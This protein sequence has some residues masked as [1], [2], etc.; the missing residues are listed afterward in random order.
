[1][2]RISAYRASLVLGSAIS[3]LVAAPAFAESSAETAAAEAEAAAAANEIV[4]SGSPIRD[5]LANSL[6]LQRKAPNIISAITADDA[7]QFPDQT[8]AAA[9][10][11]LPGIG[12]QR[13]Q[14]QERYVQVRGAPTRW[15]VVSFDDVNIL[16][17][18]ERVFRFD[19]VPAALISTVELNKTLLPDMPAEA[20]A[21]RVNIKTYSAMANPGFHGYIDL[22]YGFVDLGN[23]PQEQAA[24]RLS[25]SN[26]TFGITVAGSHSMFEQQTDNSE[27]RYEAATGALRELRN[28]KYIIE[29]EIN[30]LS[31]K[32]EFKPSDGHKITATSLYTEF[33]DHEQRNQYTFTFA[34]PDRTR[35]AGNVT[36]ARV[37]GAFE[38]GEY[39]TSTF[40]NM[41]RGEHD[42]GRLRLSW[43][44]AYVETE[45][46]TALPIIN[47]TSSTAA[48]RP[49]VSY[50]TGK[51]NLP[52]LSITN[53]NGTTGFLDQQAFDG[54][55]LTAYM[56]GNK[57]KSYTGKIDFDYDWSDN[58]SLAFGAQYDSRKLTDPGQF[59]LLRPDGT[60]GTFAPRAVA[61]A[62]GQPWT[63]GAFVTPI[64]VSEDLDRGYAFNYLDNKGMRSQLDALIAAARTAN[65]NGAN[66]AV[67]ENNPALANSVKER[68]IAGYISNSWTWDRLSLVA[69]VRVENTRVASSGAALVGSA[70]TPISIANEFTHVFPSLHVSFDAT[71][72]IKLRAAFVS[73]AARPSFADQRAT[74]TINDAAGLTFVSGGNPRLKPERAFG[75]DASVEWYFA[76]ASLLSVSGFYRS[77]KDTL[78][79]TTVPVGDDRFDFGGIDRSGYDYTT[80]LN[81]GNGKL[82][83]VEIAYNQSFDFLPAPF[84]GLGAQ[85]SLTLVD[86]N[87]ETLATP[88]A[89]PRR[90]AFPGTSK[91][92]TNL[93]VF[94]EKHG[95]SARVGY[96]HR[97]KWL[98]DISVDAAS[99]IYWDANQR[100]DLS[101]RYQL[102][103]NLTLYADVINV[104]NEAGI[105]FTGSRQTPYEVEVFGTRYLFGVKANF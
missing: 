23:G 26:D 69:G 82:Y 6:E 78:F 18:E 8:V 33:L 57:T 32:I 95:F 14:G 60:A 99:D 103:K 58:A 37:V 47:Q 72:K 91:R 70:L 45:S 86:G 35:T 24:A 87:F 15:T 51:Y 85:A 25:W 59:A 16:G 84:D 13:D 66:L 31:A 34:G 74:V 63:P 67:P 4:V 40:V 61:A 10:S 1:M 11:R 49:D 54:E 79:E 89:G 41:L 39:K 29:R 36:D 2:N 88:S 64:R 9:L 52:V 21:G 75:G 38:Q 7:G 17:A 12:V 30:S 62:V 50:A 43:N 22:G 81:G 3:T 105:R 44:A 98:D 101:F 97:T 92:I 94:Y 80:T 73:G 93:S 27:P 77:V 28:A 102:I 53:A 65:A 96:Q 104:T 48:L 42:F 46:K 19:S 55:S 68:V 90:V 20:L 5:S 83:G 71:D 100:V 56:M 76:P